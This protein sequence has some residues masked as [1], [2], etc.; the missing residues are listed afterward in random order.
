MVAL[1]LGRVQPV[2][3]NKRLLSE[4]PTGPTLSRQA[5]GILD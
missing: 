5:L 1:G 2:A 3:M 4:L